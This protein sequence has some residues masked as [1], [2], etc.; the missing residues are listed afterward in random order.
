MTVRRFT[1]NS[2]A[3]PVT[4]CRSPAR[5]RTTPLSLTGLLKM[6][7]CELSLQMGSPASARGRIV[8]N[9]DLC[10][11]C[12]GPLSSGTCLRCAEQSSRIVHRDILLLVVLSATAVALFLFTRAMATKQRQMDAR[13]AAA[14]F[15]KAEGQVRAGDMERAIESFRKAASNDR[16][17]RE[18]VV[19]L[20]NAL[21]AAGHNE[22]ARQALLRLRE[23]LPENAEINLYLARLAAKRGDVAEAV[24]YYHNALY[25]LWTGSEV[26]RER[27][28]VRVE[29]IHFLL[30]RHERSGALSEVLILGAE[31]PDGDA[32]AQIETGQLFLKAGD[33]QHALRHFMRAIGLNRNNTAALAGAGNAAFQLGDYVQAGRYL[34][35]A[36]AQGLSSESALQLLTVTKMISSNDPLA[37]HLTRQE[38]N[39]R[40]LVDFEQSLRRLQS[41]LDQQSGK[42]DS[43]NL[44]LE[45]LKADALAM[46][47]KLQP[48]NLRRDP[49]LLRAGM[50]LIYKIQEATSVSCGEPAGLD[51]ALL[52]IGRKHSGALQ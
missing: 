43:M 8:A 21:A 9:P 46:Q 23:S 33:A 17:N 37:P 2:F 35:A 45:P 52:L 42:K 1:G 41:C 16:D 3:G 38:R 30:D 26:D 51:R 19:A 36:L 10:P 13:V 6:G 18:Y 39:S 15:R 44:G 25:G 7:R 4:S 50:E 27:R 47:S 31:I 22:E 49:E 34:E 20:A 12:G 14:W 11:N 32:A 29:L 48:R 5:L 28:K 40:V 24:R